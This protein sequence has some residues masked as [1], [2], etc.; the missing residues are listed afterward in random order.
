MNS[1]KHIPPP[2]PELSGIL[3]GFVGR[4]VA[5]VWFSDY[6]VMYLEFGEVI[7]P[8]RNNPQHEQTI[9]LGYDW[10]LDLPDSGRV[11][12]FDRDDTRV[13]AL[14]R[15]QKLLSIDLEAD[16][17]LKIVFGSGSVLRTKTEDDG[18]PDWDARD[19]DR[20]VSIRDGEWHAEK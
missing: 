14:L 6:S 1:H 15:G 18:G 4:T 5:S 17:E 19:G 12:R 2:P 11:Q 16:G 9:F 20:W 13:D 7:A 8:R 3:A 10:I